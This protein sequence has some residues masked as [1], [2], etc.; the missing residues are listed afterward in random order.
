[1]ELTASP[2]VQGKNSGGEAETTAGTKSWVSNQGASHASNQ[3]DWY[4]AISSEPETIGSKT[5]YA[6]YVT[7]EY[8]E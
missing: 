6:L 4:V 2:G 5:N 7:M 8:L 1:M 3:H